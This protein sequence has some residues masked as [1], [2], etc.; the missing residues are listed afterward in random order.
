M[1]EESTEIGAYGGLSVPALCQSES[2]FS[3]EH[4]CG[5]LAECVLGDAFSELEVISWLG[6]DLTVV[7]AARVSHGSQSHGQSQLSQKDKDLIKFLADHKHTSPFRHVQIQFRVKAPEFVARQWYK[8]II[9]AD[10]AFK[11][12]AW[13]EISQRYT[14]ATAE[15]YTPLE[16]RR[17]SKRNK[18]GSESG[19]DLSQSALTGYYY[20]PTIKRSLWTYDQLLQ[21]GVAREQARLVLPLSVYTEFYWTASLQAVCH[22]INLRTEPGAQWEIQKYGDAMRLLAT[23]V[24]PFSVQ[25]LTSLI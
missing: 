17:Q 7:N 2:G 24:A 12:T 19:F 6:G 11:D 16:W 10:Y 13:N 14:E 3:G 8:H 22:F 5:T 18:Q 15:F 9:G 20:E 23:R 4:S 25:A 21:A 1:V